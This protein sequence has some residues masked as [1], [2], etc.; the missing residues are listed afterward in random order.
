MKNFSALVLLLLC[1]CS[2]ASAQEARPL[3]LD[4]AF[5]LALRRSETLSAGGEGVKQLDAFR[6]AQDAAFRPG[7]SAIASET[8]AQGAAGR[9]Q[10]ALNLSYNLFSGMRDYLAAQAAGERTEAARLEL[11]RARQSLYLDV[12]AACIDLS[13]RRREIAVR[14]AQLEVTAGRAEELE[15]RAAIGR[16]R[17]SEVLAA[18]AQ[19]AQD[20]ASLAS[21]LAGE[22]SAQIAL[23]FLTGLEG[24]LAPAAAAVPELPELEPYLNAARARPDVAAARRSLAA[25]QSTEAAARR[26]GLPSLDLSA[27]YYLKR[28]APNEDSRWDAG[29]TL[30]VPLY[31]G[32]YNTASA[33]QYG[34]QAAVAAHLLALAER[35]ALTEV[36]QAHSSLRHSLLVM[37]SLRSALALAGENARLQ[38]KD[39]TYGLVTNLDVLNAQNSALQTALNLE[40]ASAAAA[41]AAARL[42]TAAGLAPEVK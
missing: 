5:K 38:A 8:A 40:A 13:A 27:N 7:L 31:T 2:A 4:E 18:R 26:L 39:Y 3:T 1:T 29:L 33:G 20:E 42:E 24:P 17:A 34:A 12:A 30:T 32:G 37:A 15:A 14:R 35:T 11:A 36:K 19:L 25:A 9:A 6:R 16:S 21:E 28:P 23:G 41:L 10:A 22:N